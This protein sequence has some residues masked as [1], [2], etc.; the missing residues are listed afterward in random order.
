MP[1]A[2]LAMFGTPSCVRTR[3][4]HV[5]AAPV[6]CL[7]PVPTQAV[8]DLKKTARDIC[9]DQAGAPS[10]GVC[11]VGEKGTTVALAVAD[12]LGF[13]REA[14]KACQAKEREQ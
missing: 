2:T 4:V 10:K 7:P 9:H 1:L 5:P 3:Y 14:E 6:P 13:V 12:L 11:F 8:E